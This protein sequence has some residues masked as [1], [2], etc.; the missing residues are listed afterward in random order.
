MQLPVAPCFHGQIKVHLCGSVSL[1]VLTAQVEESGRLD[2]AIDHQATTLFSSSW[3][4]AHCQSKT[5]EQ[6]DATRVSVVT[7]PWCHLLLLFPLPFKQIRASYSLN[8][9][10][11]KRRKRRLILSGTVEINTM[12]HVDYSRQGNK[13]LCCVEKDVTT[14]MFACVGERERGWGKGESKQIMC[15]PFASIDCCH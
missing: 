3:P 7:S 13:H 14:S 12:S 11:L 15:Q 2:E 4:A 10:K 1:I 6:T 5:F 8:W 9:D